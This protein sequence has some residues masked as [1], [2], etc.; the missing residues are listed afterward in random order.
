MDLI[1]SITNVCQNFLHVN[2]HFQSPPA[3]IATDI[4]RTQILIK[5]SDEFT[6]PRNFSSSDREL[7]P[8]ERSHPTKLEVNRY[9]PHCSIVFLQVSSLLMTISAVDFI[10]DDKLVRINKGIFIFHSFHRNFL[11]QLKTHSRLKD[12]ALKHF[13]YHDLHSYRVLSP[14]DH[15]T[16][17]SDKLLVFTKSCRSMVREKNI[18][19]TALPTPWFRPARSSAVEPTG[20]YYVMLKEASRQLNFTFSVIKMKG[21]GAKVNGTWTGAMGDILYRRVDIALTNA[22]AECRDLVADGSGLLC[23]LNKVFWVRIY[24]GN[25]S[26]ESVFGPFT[27]LLWVTTSVSLLIL[28]LSLFCV[29]YQRNDHPYWA[30]NVVI[31]GVLEQPYQVPQSAFK[32]RY[33]L[34]LWMVFTLVITTAYRS[35]L[36]DMLMFKNLEKVPTNFPE[37]AF[38][39][40]KL[41]FRS[42]GG[43]VEAE[44]AASKKPTHRAMMANGRLKFVSSTGECV[45]AVAMEE[46]ERTAC[47]DF[48]IF[49]E[50]VITSNV[51]IVAG[52]ATVLRRSHDSDGQLPISWMFRKRS[53]MADVFSPF[54]SRILQANLLNHWLSADLQQR[55]K[56]GAQYFRQNGDKTYRARLEAIQDDLSSKVK[57]IPFGSIVV[58][59]GLY[60]VGLVAGAAGFLWEFTTNAFHHDAGK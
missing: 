55:K 50:N 31:R 14:C 18:V 32:I 48:D 43:V 38:S 53:G 60:I 7:R 57:P 6:Q 52:D 25:Q 36:Y 13:V 51:S 47:I 23:W 37:L 10:V 3:G 4:E 26:V 41:L 34:M 24:R 40:Y 42:Y 22:L 30:V 15:E 16:N 39:D 28:G 20:S 49:G 33:V 58:L 44:W 5:Y 2:S 11:D 35:K 19:V 12:I 46:N 29:S 59:L 21:T 45:T 56:E 8:D 9:I 54:I 27:P 17:L 1:P